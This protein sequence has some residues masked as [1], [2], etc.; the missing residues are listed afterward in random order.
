MNTKEEK[1]IKHITN[2][3]DPRVSESCIHYIWQ[4]PEIRCEAKIALIPLC[5]S[6][7]SLRSAAHILDTQE[8]LYILMLLHTHA[9]RNNDFWSRYRRNDL[10]ELVEMA[11][12]EVQV[13]KKTLYCPP[14]NFF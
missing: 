4:R 10:R 11:R 12:K 3:K 5:Q 9:C 14:E 1:I 7:Q 8:K 13:E 6:E 2:L